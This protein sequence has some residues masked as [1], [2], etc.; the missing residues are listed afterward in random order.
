MAVWGAPT[1]HEDD[2]ERAV[3][4]ALEL[5]DAVRA[6]GPNVQA[7]AGVLTGEAAVTIGATNQ[8][9]V[10]GDLV[11]TASRLQ[12]A[13]A[14]GTV[15]VGEATQRAASKAI[16]FE[17]A[18]EQT[19]KGKAAPGARLARPAGRGAGRRPQSGGRD[20]GAVRRSRRRAPAA[21]GPLP[22]HGPRAADAPRVGHRPGRHRQDPPRLGVPQVRRR[23]RRPTSGGTTD[24]ARP[25]ARASASGPSARW[26]APGLVCWRPT[27]RPR[28]ARR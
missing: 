8:G 5:V 9:M 4:A 11:N 22:R 27:T 15:L 26:S 20:G 25:T 12:S 13:A 6:L 3:R 16:A 24:G 23:T 17:E 28:P 10:A 21:Q 1:A 7:R 19:L 2:A 18:G 14:P